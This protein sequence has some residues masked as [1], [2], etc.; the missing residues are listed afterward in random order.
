[1]NSAPFLP[2]GLAERADSLATLVRERL[3]TPG[4]AE[5]HAARAGEQTDLPMWSGSSLSEGH[6][7]LAL[8]H[9]HAGDHEA[10]FRFLRAAF[11]ATARSPLTHPGLFDGTAG[12]ALVLEDCCAAEPRF[13]PSLRALRERLCGQV[14]HTAWPRREGTVSDHDYDLVYGSAGI[15]SHLSTTPHKTPLVVQAVDHCLDHLV[16]LG[17]ES[18]EGVPARWMISPERYSA[19][20]D[21]AVTYPYGYLDTG[22]SHGAAGMAAA[23]AVAWREGHRRPGHREALARLT[24]WLL[25]VGT[26]GGRDRQ[27]PRAVPVTAQGREG[28]AEGAEAVPAWCHGTAGVAAAL[29][30]VAEATGDRALAAEAFA[31]LDGVLAR[32]GGHATPTVCH[33]VAGLAALAHEFAARGSAGAA[34]ALPGLVERLVAAAE[35][36]RHPL[37]FRDRETTGHLVDN[38]GLLTGAAGIAMTLRAIVTGHRPTWWKALVP[39]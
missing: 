10:A 38:P 34:R 29:L 7:G 33:G 8:L 16:W 30:T 32:G 31:A 22:M 17:T 6:A 25:A 9:L 2:A 1:M 19:Y 12:L 24:D 3:D 21:L 23:L 5:A 20:G 27:W 28:T 13:L 37:V 18:D 39:Q 11:D 14:L 26:A 15:L 36:G 4:R 35:P